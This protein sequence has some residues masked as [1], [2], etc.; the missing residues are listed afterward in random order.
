ML[1]FTHLMDE[2][3]GRSRASCMTARLVVV[4]RAKDKTQALSKIRSRHQGE[5]KSYSRARES[6][7]LASSLLKTPRIINNPG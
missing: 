4:F 5:K 1:Q 3:D 7:P 2:L 6:T